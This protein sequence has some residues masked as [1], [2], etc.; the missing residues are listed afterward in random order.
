[1]LAFPSCT[2]IPIACTSYFGSES[3]PESSPLFV[4]WSLNLPLL[5]Y[6]GKL[7]LTSHSAMQGL[8]D[9]WFQYDPSTGKGA[10]GPAILRA[11]LVIA[12]PIF[13]EPLTP[14]FVFCASP[15]SL[16]WATTAHLHLQDPRLSEVQWREESRRFGMCAIRKSFQWVPEST[17]LCLSKRHTKCLVEIDP[18]LPFSRVISPLQQFKWT[19]NRSASSPCS[20]GSG[21]L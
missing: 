21:R 1:L 3:S 11:R 14:V 19:L 4:V 7:L 10:S 17:F 20:A 13:G 15:Q 9:L 18:Q 5:L 8:A 6:F 12:S 16:Y 2:I